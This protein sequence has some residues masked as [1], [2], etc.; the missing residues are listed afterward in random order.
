[1]IHHI[2]SSIAFQSNVL[3][4][5][6][7]KRPS[8]PLTITPTAEKFLRVLHQSRQGGD[9]ENNFEDHAKGFRLS[10][11]QAPNNLHMVFSFDFLDPDWL[12]EHES[13]TPG[14]FFPM[15]KVSFA[16]DESLALY[17]DSSALMKVLGTTV[18]YDASKSSLV[19]LDSDGTEVSPES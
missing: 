6:I 12:N 19:I 2:C 18:D 11:N 8:R 4:E 9:E 16:E 13:G 14:K 3:V 5:D 17:I 7:W 15:E 10:L 1:M